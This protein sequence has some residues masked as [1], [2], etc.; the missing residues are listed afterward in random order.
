MPERDFRKRCLWPLRGW[1]E[2]N[3]EGL[4]KLVMDAMNESI[5]ASRPGTGGHNCVR[6]DFTRPWPLRGWRESNEEGL[7]KLVMDGVNESRKGPQGLARVDMKC[8]TRYFKRP[9]PLRGWRESN[10]EGLL[11]LAM[12]A[13]NEHNGERT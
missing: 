8:R 2:S 4:L 13:S 1:R 3:E 7:L 10:E 11:K 5:G 12:V 9:W 6:R